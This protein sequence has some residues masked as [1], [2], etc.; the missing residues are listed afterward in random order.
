MKK[1]LFL[2]EVIEFL[3]LENTYNYIACTNFNRDLPTKKILLPIC[4]RIFINASEVKI[5]NFEIVKIHT[6]TLCAQTFIAICQ[7]FS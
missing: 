4:I 2:A 3:N 6:I 5:S 7:L 1:I